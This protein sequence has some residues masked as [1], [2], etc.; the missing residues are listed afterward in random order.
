VAASIGSYGA[1]LHDGSEY[2]GDY[3]LTVAELRGFHRDRLRVLADAGPDV[4]AIET[5]PCLAEV[6]AVLAELDGLGVPAWLSMTCAATKTRAAE[7]AA[8]GFAMAGDSAEVFAVGVNCT[9]PADVAALVALA[10]RHSGKPAVAYPNSGE[11]WDA[12]R[13]GASLVH[14]SIGTNECYTWK[15]DTGDVDA[16]FAAADVR[17][18]VDAGARLV[19]GCCRIG[20]AEIAAVAAAVSRPS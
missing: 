10:A 12:S 5:I 1:F 18:W 9:P 13:E 2:R 11:G 20:P 6:E 17:R 3:G 8:A 15:L 19:G 14:S 7:P 16:A 4:L